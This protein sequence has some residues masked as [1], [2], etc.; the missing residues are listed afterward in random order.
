MEKSGTSFSVSRQFSSS[1]NLQDLESSKTCQIQIKFS[2]E[3]THTSGPICAEKSEPSE[4]SS[5][6]HN[7]SVFTVETTSMHEQ[8]WYT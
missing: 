4:M 7:L 5:S 1:R 6:G 3:Q 2:I 8:I